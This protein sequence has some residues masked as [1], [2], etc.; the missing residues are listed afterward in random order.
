MQFTPG[1]NSVL[2]PLHILHFQFLGN[3]T[4]HLIPMRVAIVTYSLERSGLLRTV[5]SAISKSRLILSLAI[6]LKKNLSLLKDLGLL[7]FFK[8][9]SD[10]H[11]SYTEFRFNRRR[12][13][14]NKPP[15]S[16]PSLMYSQTLR[17]HCKRLPQNSIWKSTLNS[18]LLPS[19]YS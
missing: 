15:H 19:S 6:S 13:E 1:Y 9:V 14:D 10:L 17:I 8:L 7:L 4:L 5:S 11:S 16:T 3:R 18:C 2:H 12:I